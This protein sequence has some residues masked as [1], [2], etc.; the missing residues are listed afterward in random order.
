MDH[1]V[2]L[3]DLDLPETLK[4]VSWIAEEEEKECVTFVKKINKIQI[5]SRLICT[6]ILT[7]KRKLAITQSI[8]YNKVTSQWTP[9]DCPSGQQLNEASDVCTDCGLGFYR[10][11][12]LTWTCQTCPQD[13][14][15]SGTR[16]TSASDCSVCKRT[17]LYIQLDRPI[18]IVWKKNAG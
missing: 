1:W 14:T 4:N 13:L 7:K 9:G 6:Q 12:T 16:S 3:Y 17:F 11:A 5:Q 2:Q 10:D 18:L 8:S 15:T